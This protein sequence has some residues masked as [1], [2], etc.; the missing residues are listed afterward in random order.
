M[1]GTNVST[2]RGVKVER[3]KMQGDWRGKSATSRVSGLGGKS[4]PTAL[5]VI[6]GEARSPSDNVCGKKVIR[7]G[8]AVQVEIV[9]SDHPG[10]HATRGGVWSVCIRHEEKR[11]RETFTLMRRHDEPA[12]CILSIHHEIAS[13]YRRG[14]EQ[15]I[16]SFGLRADSNPERETPEHRVKMIRKKWSG[17]KQGRNLFFSEVEVM[18]G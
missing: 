2:I 13:F 15:G 1:G 14:H 6:M 7:T 5:C 9:L 12:R 18:S 3:S 11:D 10:R 17:K 16:A 4:L 8:S